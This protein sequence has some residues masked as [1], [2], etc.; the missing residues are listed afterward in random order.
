MLRQDVLFELESDYRGN[1][2]HISGNAILHALAHNGRIDYDEQRQLRVSH[3]VFCPSVY[4]VYPHWHSQNSG[5]MSF[6]STL[7]PIETYADLFL[8]RRPSH[9]WIHDGRPRDAVN[10]PGYRKH[11]GEYLLTASQ[12]I[13]TTDGKPRKSQ[14][15][16]H[17]YLTQSDGADILPL[18]ESRLDGIQLG[19]KRNYGY[20]AVSIK[21][22][23]TTDI[24]E[25]DYSAI[26]N[27]DSH[28]LELLSPYVLTSEYPQVDNKPVPS[29]W[30]S[31]LNYRTRQ[32]I[33]VD[34][35]EQYELEVVDYGQVTKYCGN[36]PTETARNGVSRIGSHS[37]YGYGEFMVRP[38]TK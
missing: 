29:W 10:T 28:V 37:K 38:T 35:R 5:R 36:R 21:D 9:P 8:F 13:Q 16:I 22:T 15:Y 27:A 30:D 25:L 1:P 26:E 3:G 14:W 11:N 12:A 19:G 31:N 4:G 6:A 20:G 34:Q 7:K 17:A 24:S 23:M 18:D 2:H 33:I 32:D